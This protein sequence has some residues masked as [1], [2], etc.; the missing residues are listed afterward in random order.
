[1]CGSTGYSIRCAAADGHHSTRRV[2]SASSWK[3]V[4]PVSK[5][6][7]LLVLTFVI[8]SWHPEISWARTDPKPFVTFGIFIGRIEEGA[9][10]FTPVR[11]LPF[12]HPESLNHQFPNA[13]QLNE[14]EYEA[15]VF[16]G[17]KVGLKL[18]TTLQRY[19][20]QP[21]PSW[22]YSEFVPPPL[23]DLKGAA[24]RRLNGRRSP[25]AGLRA[26]VYKD[27]F[28]ICFIVDTR[29]L[30]LK[31]RNM[32]RATSMGLDISRSQFLGGLAKVG[33]FVPEKGTWILIV[34]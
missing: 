5:I 30:T 26:V 1:M 31:Q 15:L 29:N 18:S 12:E 8:L 2:V 11:L 9:R 28:P 25:I 4:G 7:F 23:E 19:P 10:I 24:V 16:L 21:T 6:T 17:E 33:G 32:N 3:R 13:L 14:R 20:R 34:D 22:N 27:R